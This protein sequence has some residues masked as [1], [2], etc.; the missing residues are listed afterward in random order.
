MKE[1]KEVYE[2]P[3]IFLILLQTA[4]ISMT[5]FISSSSCRVVNSVT[6]FITSHH[7]FYVILCE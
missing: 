3:A 1:E 7:L 6:I 4:K 5:D 2:D